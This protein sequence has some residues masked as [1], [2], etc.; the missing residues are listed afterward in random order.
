MSDWTPELA[1][2][3]R[4][5]CEAA[6]PGPLEADVDYFSDEDDGIMAVVDNHDSSL[7]FLSATEIAP[8]GDD[9]WEKTKASQQYKDAVFFAHARTDLPAALDRVEAQ[10]DEIERLRTA[11][12]TYVS[13][14][15]T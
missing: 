13:A 12:A 3:M 8:R 5:R 11:L 1:K 10:E 2:E 7:F 4:K 9:S 6:T 15:R 14:V